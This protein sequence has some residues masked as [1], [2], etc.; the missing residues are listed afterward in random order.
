MSLSPDFRDYEWRDCSNCQ[1][2]F[3]ARS[4][5]RRTICYVCERVHKELQHSVLKTD[6]KVIGFPEG[7]E[8]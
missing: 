6:E 3:S 2:R 4:I 5:D 7:A 8:L 1:K